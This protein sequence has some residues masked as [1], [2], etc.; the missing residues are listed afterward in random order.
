MFSHRDG[1]HLFLGENPILPVFAERFQD[2]VS[3][4]GNRRPLV[5]WYRGGV[6]RL[7]RQGVT[8]V[9]SGWGVILPCWSESAYVF[10]M[11][12]GGF[13]LK[14]DAVVQVCPCYLERYHWVDSLQGC[15]VVW[16]E[17]CIDG[18]GN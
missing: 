4:V 16:N 17:L 3:S 13:G 14:L 18:M 8:S 9:P 15:W 11:T 1:R 5:C 2:G 12:W 6:R 10:G 7:H